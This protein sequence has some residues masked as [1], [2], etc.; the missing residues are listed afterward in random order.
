[1]RLV[2]FQDTLQHIDCGMLE[3]LESL[4]R[5]LLHLRGCATVIRADSATRNRPILTPLT[6]LL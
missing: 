4:G 6:A 2:G 3:L 5:F 1:V